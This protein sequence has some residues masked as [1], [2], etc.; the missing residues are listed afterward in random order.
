MADDLWGKSV[1]PAQNN[2][3]PPEGMPEGMQAGQVNDSWRENIAFLRRYIADLCAEDGAGNI[4]NTAGDGSAYTLTVQQQFTALRAGMRFLARAH[5]QNNGACTLTVTPSGQS[6]LTAKSIKLPGDFDPRAGDILPGQLI[7]F[8]WN[9]TGDYFEITSPVTAALLPFWQGVSLEANDKT[10]VESDDG[11]L[12]LLDGNANA[13]TITL[14]TTPRDGTTFGFIAFNTTNALTVSRGGTDQIVAESQGTTKN[15]TVS[16]GNANAFL[17]LS[18]YNGLWYTASGDR[19]AAN[20]LSDPYGDIRAAWRPEQLAIGSGGRT[21]PA[22][23]M[24]KTFNVT[25]TTSNIFLPSSG[26]T[27]L[28]GNSRVLFT[29]SSGAT[30][31][32]NG[33]GGDLIAYSAQPAGVSS[34]TLQAGETAAFRFSGGNLYRID[35]QQAP[36]LTGGSGSSNGMELIETRTVSATTATVDFTGLADYYEVH[37]EM[38]ATP[39]Q[40]GRFQALLGDST[41]ISPGN[42]TYRSGYGLF[43]QAGGTSTS[44]LEFNGGSGGGENPQSGQETS[45]VLVFK[46]IGSTRPVMAWTGQYPSNGTWADGSLVGAAPNYGNVE[47]IRLQRVGGGNW[48]SAGTFN[49]YGI[50]RP[51]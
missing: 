26:D 34:V 11:T 50:K 49:V 33:Q 6:A 2:Q 48:I 20:R 3:T 35:S 14:P 8:S 46:G 36:S 16:L 39:A 32:I 45:G 19:I 1:T 42:M 9:N 25:Q 43:G 17:T 41:G 27:N 24:G 30:A 21:L 22:T 4:L 31:T 28:K 5:V 12:V 40:N 44:G 7:E 51:T 23:D 10:L 18:Y 38:E 47:Q 29:V 37:I 13:V 15:N